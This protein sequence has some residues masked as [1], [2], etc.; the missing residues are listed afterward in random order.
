MRLAPTTR[1]LLL[2]LA[3]IPLL[4][5]GRA[6]AFGK[7]VPLPPAP[8]PAPAPATSP[9]TG[10]LDAADASSASGWAYDASLGAQPVTVHIY[11][12]GKLLVAV[13]AN[14]ARPD[15]V[16][17]GAAPDANHG[18]T[19]PLA[20]LAPGSHTVDA[21]AIAA[22]GQNPK[23]QGSGKTVNVPFTPPTP[24]TPPTTRT[25]AVESL[26]PAG[27]LTGYAFDPAQGGVTVE[28]WADGARGQGRFVGSVWA[29]GARL[30]TLGTQTG[31]EWVAPT[32]LRDGQP[33]RLFVYSVDAQGQSPLELQGSQ[34][35]VFQQANPNLGDLVLQGAEIQVSTQATFGGAC[36]GITWNGVQ[37][38]NDNDHGRQCQTAWTFGYGERLNP[39]EAGSGHDAA[40]PTRSVVLAAN[41]SGNTLTTT[42]HAAFWDPPGTTSPNWG[43]TGTVSALNG[44]E[45]SADLFTKTVTVDVGGDP[46]LIRWVNEITL[47]ADAPQLVV[48]CP[49]PYVDARFSAFYTYDPTTQTLAPLDHTPADKTGNFPPGAAVGEQGLPVILA[50]PGGD[51]AIGVYSGEANISY[52]RFDFTAFGTQKSNVVCR[53]SNVPGAQ[54]LRL[55]SYIAVGTL[56]Q[57]QASLQ[58]A[59]AN[60]P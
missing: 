17:A 9:P 59:Y 15:L 11:V 20:G 5:P 47:F 56:A 21:Y 8:A 12:D 52:G 4:G 35:F 1:A 46:H 34:S 58:N 29:N 18:F 60:R 49:T 43:G 38:V 6:H 39:T 14:G 37:F 48:E 40:G 10:W 7:P 42:N 23:L 44:S 2:T 3:T 53:R 19:A 51:H 28:V 33:H 16:T 55:T 13:T 26:S 31:F 27:E 41:V 22:S 24:G 25:G 54:P 30:S 45:V 50:T 36:T 57:V 32:Y